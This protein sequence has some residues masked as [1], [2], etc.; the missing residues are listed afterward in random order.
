[1]ARHLAATLSDDMPTAV[2][3]AAPSVLEDPATQ[4]NVDMWAPISE[5]DCEIGPLVNTSGVHPPTSRRHSPVVY[6]YPIS[7]SHGANRDGAGLAGRWKS[8]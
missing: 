6:A 7:R 1:M 2:L 8:Y 4:P 3:C 5:S